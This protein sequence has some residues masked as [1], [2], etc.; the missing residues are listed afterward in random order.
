LKN[1]NFSN[2]KKDLIRVNE[3]GSFIQ[4]VSIVFSGNVVGFIIQLVFSPILSRIFDPVA[5][6]E[7]AFLNIIVTNIVF[8]S[9]LSLP[10][11]YILPKKLKDFYSLG[12]LVMVFLMV[13]NLGF[14]LVFLFLYTNEYNQIKLL[15]IGFTVIVATTFNSMFQFFNSMNVRIKRFYIRTKSV[16]AGAFIGKITAVTIGLAGAASGLSL[17]F[18]DLSKNLFTLLLMVRRRELKSFLVFIFKKNSHE[19]KEVL[20]KNKSVVKYIFP[21][22]LLTK[23]SGDLPIIAIGALVGTESLGQFTFAITFLTLPQRLIENSIQPVMFQKLTDLHQKDIQRF[24]NFFSKVYSYSIWSSFIPIT[25]LSLL[26][27]FVFSFVF[28]NEWKD[29]GSIASLLSV[30][31]IAL[32]IMAPYVSVWRIMKREKQLFFLNS[33]SLVFRLTPLLLLFTDI[34]FFLFVFIYACISSIV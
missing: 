20:I 19:L 28:G 9:A 34:N 33:A 25:I 7:Y 15:S 2:F 12:K 26:A 31:Y 13:A 23:F 16:T 32:A 24:K 6:G 17:L 4:N 1:K 3:K 5:Y 11:V 10:S 14:I 21:S 30:R 18:S 8:C 22:Q 27:P 29:S